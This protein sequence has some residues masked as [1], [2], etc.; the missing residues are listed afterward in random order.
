M[1]TINFAYKYNNK[2]LIKEY[3]NILH[4]IRTCIPN[5]LCYRQNELLGNVCVH[6]S[7]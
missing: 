2:K 5:I 3:T 7:V 6:R 4:L 1:V